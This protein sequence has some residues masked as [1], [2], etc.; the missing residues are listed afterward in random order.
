MTK[1]LYRHQLA[2][3]WGKSEITGS[4]GK[5]MFN[6]LSKCQTLF[7]RWLRHFTFPP[8]VCEDHSSIS[9]PTLGVTLLYNFH[10]SN[11]YEMVFDCGSHCIALMT[12]GVEHLSC[13]CLTPASPLVKCLFKSLPLFLL[14]GLFS[15]LCL[16]GR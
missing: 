12:N 11:R 9:S 2:F 1:S 10:H 14:G 4:Y 8:A 15:F 7:Q 6:F 16:I 3:V 5:C 13:D